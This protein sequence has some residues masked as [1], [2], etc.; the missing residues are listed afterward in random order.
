MDTILD[1]ITG[2]VAAFTVFLVALSVSHEFGYFVH[3]GVPFFQTFVSATDYLTNAILWAPVGVISAIAWYNLGWLWNSP[4]L[5]TKGDWRSWR[6]PAVI[7]GLPLLIF[8]FAPDG[9]P[10][11]YFSPVLYLW[12]ILFDKFMPGANP[13]TR[14]AGEL[15]SL[16][17]IVVPICVAAFIIG[18]DRAGGDLSLKSGPYLLQIKGHD[19]VSL[20][21][22]LR[23]FD[24]GILVK[25][26]NSNRIEFMK[27]DQVESVSKP[28]SGQSRSLGCYLFGFLCPEQ[29][30]FP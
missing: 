5:P 18:Y 30:P 11:L 13:K 19:H 17:K 23:N 25:D 20:R 12:V 26:S 10:L 16:L 28:I 8:I 1:K 24:K 14:L 22:P 7:I 15:R 21:I 4:P 9:I 3:L 27:W 2:L 29:P 6:A